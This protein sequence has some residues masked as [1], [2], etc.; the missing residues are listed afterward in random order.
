MLMQFDSNAQVVFRLVGLDVPVLVTKPW[1]KG[2]KRAYLHLLEAKKLQVLNWIRAQRNRPGANFK[3]FSLELLSALR[4]LFQ[5]LLVSCIL[6]ENS[7]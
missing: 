6:I 4:S 3:Q 1:N 5:A 7:G 2:S